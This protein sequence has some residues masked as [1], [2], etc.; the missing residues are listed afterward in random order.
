MINTILIEPNDMTDIHDYFNNFALLNYTYKYNNDFINL[1]NEKEFLKIINININENENE[2]INENKNVNIDEKFS[3]I[4]IS[5]FNIT[6][7][8]K[9]LFTTF[10]IYSN[11]QYIYYI[12]YDENN[13]D[14]LLQNDI[15]FLLTRYYYYVNGNSV[16]FKYS[17]LNDNY[18]DFTIN[19]LAIFISNNYL[20]N[21]I[22]FDYVNNI[23]YKKLGFNYSDV[24][25]NYKYNLIQHDNINYYLYK[26]NDF[27]N[28][29]IRNK[30][31]EI[32]QGIDELNQFKLY[33]DIY[34]LF[35][36]FITNDVD[37]INNIIKL[38]I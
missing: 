36:D 33:P 19:D 28:I 18:V 27:Y 35:S 8:S 22:K 20:V 10:T 3:D 1:L 9:H 12:V 25:F 34:N 13:N 37:F 38:I 6:D 24:Y 11:D 31:I 2:N 30:T 4:L 5:N 26:E 23:I 17:K 29:F 15:G 14:K 7:P 32:F 16:L 21:Y